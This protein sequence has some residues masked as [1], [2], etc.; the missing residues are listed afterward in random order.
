MK[1]EKK[2]NKK[3]KAIAIII[4]FVLA[5]GFML[6]WQVQSCPTPEY[7][8]YIRSEMTL[9]DW[10]SFFIDSNV[11]W[12]GG[13]LISLG[14]IVVFVILGSIL[15]KSMAEKKVKQ[16]VTATIENKSTTHVDSITNILD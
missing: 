11:Y 14:I 1:K 4:G 3:A 7:Y 12:F 16:E 10:G 8:G 15:G 5:I 2:I 13:A 9:S 6:F